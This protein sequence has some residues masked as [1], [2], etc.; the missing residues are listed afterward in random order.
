[1][2]SYNQTKPKRGFTLIELLIVIAIIAILAAMLLP[3]LAQAKARALRSQCLSNLKQW[4][5]SQQIYASDNNSSLPCDGM[6]SSQEQG[7]GT[8]CGQWQ[9]QYGYSGTVAD[10][11]AWFNQLPASM[12][13][14]TLYSYYTAMTSGR[15]LNG[16]TKAQAYMPFPGNGKGPVFECPSA[17]MAETTITEGPP[18]GLATADNPPPKDPGPGGTGFFSYAMNID[19]KRGSD[20]TTPLPWPQM[21]LLTAFRQPSATVCMFDI[22]FDPATE[23]IVGDPTSQQF[24]SV[25]PAGRYRSYAS[26]HNHG[27]VI[28]FLDGHSGYYLTYYVTNGLS[29]VGAKPTIGGYNEPLLPDI[30]WDAPYRGAE[31]GM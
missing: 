29:T 6:S 25:N 22:V 23:G 3:V 15:G 19:L 2:N 24:N 7:G 27:G 31:M 13:V 18:N 21:P 5:T 10:P 30:V 26:R 8:Y 1:M 28:N 11:Y 14:G 9:A 20:G 4:G 17:S 16:N 12:G